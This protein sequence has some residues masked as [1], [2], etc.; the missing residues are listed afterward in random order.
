MIRL[1]HIKIS[2]KHY[3]H[4]YSTLRLVL[5]DTC[6]FHVKESAIVNQIFSKSLPSTCASSTSG[7]FS[8]DSV[9]SWGTLGTSPNLY[10]LLVIR[11]ALGILRQRSKFPRSLPWE[12][13]K[14]NVSCKFF[15]GTRDVRSIP[16]VI[17]LTAVYKTLWLVWF[18]CV[19]LESCDTWPCYPAVHHMWQTV[20]S[21]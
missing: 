6:W 15:S 4:A 10:L 17:K 1:F 9:T 2:A 7:F 16:R 11:N 3:M 20:Q 19:F 12:P 14:M 13:Q 18:L 21:S 8:I 5:N